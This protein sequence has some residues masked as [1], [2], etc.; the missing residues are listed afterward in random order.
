MYTYRIDFQY[1]EINNTYRKEW[2]KT[3]KFIKA[4]TQKNALKDFRLNIDNSIFTIKN[5]QIER[6]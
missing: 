4:T 3:F 1:N 2:K 5:I 6:M